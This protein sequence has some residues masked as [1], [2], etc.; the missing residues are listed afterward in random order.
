M[1]GPFD[2]F[3]E[4]SHPDHKGVTPEQYANRMLLREAM[5]S[6]GFAPVKEEWWQFTE[7]QSHLGSL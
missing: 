6:G 3:G 5:E 4:L 1:G 2:F 7:L